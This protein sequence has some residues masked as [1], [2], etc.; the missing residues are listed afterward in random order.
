MGIY[1]KKRLAASLAYPIR[2]TSGNLAL[3]AVLAALTSFLFFLHFRDFYTSDSLSYVVP[4]ANILAGHGFVNS[5]GYP[6][7]TRT[8]GYPLLI[9]PFL[10]A[11]AD[12][13]Y[14]II[15]Q[16]LLRGL[17]VLATSA[18]AFRLTRSRRV[19]LLTGVLL[20]LDLPL[21]YETNFIMAEIEFTATLTVAL[22]LLWKESQELGTPRIRC[23]AAGLLAGASAL[24]RP[25]SILLLLPAGTYLL[26]ARRGFK[27]RAAFSFCLAFVCL[28]LTWATRNYY[29]TGYFTV[30]S[31][32][33]ASML[34]YRAAGV[35]AVNDSGE[36]YANLEKRQ[37][38][39]QTQACAD[40][41]SLFG[42]DCS[43]V[44]IPQK[45][46]YYSRLGRRIIL[47]RPL[48]YAKLVLRGDAV[49]LLGGSLTRLRE[50]TGT[51]PHVGMIL[52][53]SYTFPVLCFAIMGLVTLWKTNRQ[54]F[55][56]VFLVSLYFLA[57][58]GGAESDSRFRVPIIPI[59][60][61]AA[62][63]GLDSILRR[64]MPKDDL[65]GFSAAD[66]LQPVR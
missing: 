41:R 24:I 6:E 65:A 43:Q 59:Y 64:L 8:P 36:F 27:V 26:F 1:P 58:S 9:V 34:L 12:L 61:L 14:L 17:I 57:I 53:L 21:L 40:I 46:E 4:A 35:L 33:G 54:L 3:I 56:L 48:A 50:M 66:T 62:A 7:T 39:L 47:A 37:T 38:E 55:L 51:G 44:T 13:K 63:T 2:T 52:L 18:F 10:W 19:A 28:P 45:L 29:E 42:T 60:A 20:C 31:I 16:H 11:R 49:M 25:V 22:W 32:S 23:F 30:S 5:E 15:F